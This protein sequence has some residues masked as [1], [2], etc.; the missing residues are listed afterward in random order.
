MSNDL[1]LNNPVNS[2]VSGGAINVGRDL[3]VGA[4]HGGGSSAITM[5]GSGA[6]TITVNGAGIF[7]S[8][9]VTINKT[10]GTASLASNLTLSSAGQD[11]TITQGTFDLA[12]YNLTLTAAGDVL[13]VDAN[14]I[15]QLQGGETI[16]ATTKTL[17]AGS[18]VVYNGAGAYGSLIMGNSYSNLTFNGSGSWTHTGALDVNG[19]LTISSGMLTSAGQNA[20]V[21][22]NWSNAGTYTSGANTV[23]FD[24]TNQQISGNSSFNHFTKSVA[25]GDTLTFAAGSTTTI[26]G[27][28]TLTCSSCPAG[29]YLSLRSGTPGSR[30]NFPLPATSTIN[31]S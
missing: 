27:T 4:T 15:L 3:T 2:V 24:G 25:S 28:A 10:A 5:N 21:A 31:T 23:I 17:N 22:G 11:L 7:P 20:N 1:Y 26:N 19:N 16:T 29:Q 18:T 9:T 8:A 12:G 30:L 6:Q 13:T 14:G